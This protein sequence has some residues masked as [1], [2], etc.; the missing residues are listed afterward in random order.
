AE[1]ALQLD[2]NL[3]D[4]H[5]ARAVIASDGEWDLQKAL[6][7]FERALELRPGYAAA[8]M[9]YGQMLGGLPLERFDEARQ[10]LDRA[11]QLDPLMPWNDI[12]LVAWWL[13]Q[14]HPEKALEEAERA[15]PLNPTVWELRWQMGF[16]QLLRLQPG[17]A[18]PQCE[19]AVKLC[20]PDRPA[21]VLA[22][23]GLAYGLAGRRTDA[24]NI[25]AEMELASQKRYISPY[26]LAAVYSG[27]GRM[28][29]AFRLLDQA[30]ERRTPWLVI[31]CTRYDPLSVALRRDPRW[32]SF[33]DQLRRQVR[34][35]PGTPNPYS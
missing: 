25:L 33:I 22:P 4:A 1:R 7:H 30:L 10:H 28:D 31:C 35:P 6:Q 5:K 24:I 11:R 15:A 13:W 18:V 16:A 23:L 20:Q 34:L 12:S 9:F 14:G 3:A 19:A 17:L 8:H 26:D 21:A 29:E 27:L 2:E 32:K